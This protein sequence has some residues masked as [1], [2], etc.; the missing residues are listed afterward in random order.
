LWR[1]YLAFFLFEYAFAACTTTV[2]AG[3]LM[4]RSQMIAYFLYSILV[5]G[6]VYPIIVHAIW[7]YRGFL[8]AHAN[9]PLYGVGMNDFA[10]SGVVHFTG[11]LISLAATSV[12]GPRRGRFHDE[13][14][15]KLD[16]PREFPGQSVSLQVIHKSGER[17]APS[18]LLSVYSSCCLRC[19]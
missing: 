6:F 12:L 3:T 9:D 5:A 8:S 17:W 1:S 18:L 19:A 11:G 7:N 4:E 14:G 2:V 10:G 13:E 15:R 16:K